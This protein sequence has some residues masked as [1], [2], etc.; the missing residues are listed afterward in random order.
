M[1]RQFQSD[2]EIPHAAWELYPE[3]KKKLD[4]IIELEENFETALSSRKRVCFAINSEPE[5]KI[6]IL[7]IHL[8]H[9]FIATTAEEKAY[10]IISIEG[11]LL[12]KSAAKMLPFGN[13]F[14]KIRM[15]L[16]KRQNPINNVFEWSAENHPEGMKGNC[17]QVKVPGDKPFPIKMFLHRSNDIR[18]RYEISPF[19]RELLPFLQ[20]DPTE[21]QVL[22]AMWGYISTMGL[23]DSRDR[24]Q[25]KCNI[26]LKNLFNVDQMVLSSIKQRLG[27]HMT[28]C[29]PI[30]VEYNVTTISSTLG[31]SFGPVAVAKV[32]ICIFIYMY[33]CI[34]I[35]VNMHIYVLIYICIYINICIYIYVYIYIFIYMY[36]YIY[37][38]I[39]V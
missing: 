13:Y 32:Y 9:Q 24:R 17:F 34:C 25:I 38:Y 2:E 28:P 7:R 4:K 5:I 26:A 33:I 12:D 29:K 18:P 19:L 22:L 10:F 31:D 20:V 35:Y 3:M 27:E 11:H 15:Q 36:I 14:D 30:Q 16:D 1:K 21:E 39:Y 6:K 8:R 23:L 37:I